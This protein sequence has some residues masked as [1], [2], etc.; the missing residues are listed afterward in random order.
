MHGIPGKLR[1]FEKLSKSQGKLKI[2][3]IFVGGPGKLSENVKSY[4]GPRKGISVN[5]LSGAAQGKI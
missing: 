3:S 2:I 5:F 4:N 1:E